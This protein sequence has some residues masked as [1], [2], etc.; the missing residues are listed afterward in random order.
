M[1]DMIENPSLSKLKEKLMNFSEEEF[2]AFLKEKAEEI[3]D[4][5]VG[6]TLDELAT[7]VLSERAEQDE[8]LQERSIMV[9]DNSQIEEDV[10]GSVSSHTLSDAQGLGRNEFLETK[11]VLEAAEGQEGLN[12]ENG[13]TELGGGTQLGVL[14]QSLESAAVIPEVLMSP[15]R[16]SP[17]LA[18]ASDEHVLLKAERRATEKNMEGNPLNNSLFFLD[19]NNVASNLKLLGVKALSSSVDKLC[20]SV[21]NHK[22]QLLDKDNWE[23][24]FVESEEEESVEEL[25]RLAVK[26]LCGELLEEVFDEDSVLVRRKKGDGGK[27]N[28]SGAKTLKRKTC[29]VN[30]SQSHS[31][32]SR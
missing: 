2:T 28:K 26:E 30:P 1:V 27:K 12:A 7:E 24:E 11:N 22:P 8:L 23:E 14:G 18:S 15:L 4:V 32:V 9:A 25:E 16:A 17:R 10:L 31:N 5:A 20:S 6:K 21:F 3:L 19:N 29:R 13:K